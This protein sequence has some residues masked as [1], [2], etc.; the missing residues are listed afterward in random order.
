MAEPVASSQSSA[1]I[2]VVIPCYDLGR[3]IEEAVDSV[4]AQTYEAAEIVIVDDESAD[5]LTRQVLERL[6]R[7]RTSVVQV[8]HGGVARAR[9]HGVSLTRSDYIVLLDADDVLDERYLER[10]AAPL[11]HDP[12]LGFVSCPTQAF[13]GADYRWTPPSTD[14]VGTL[15]RGSVHVSSMFRRALW[16]AVGG[17]DVD[18]PAYEDLDFWLTAIERGFRGQIVD[19]TVLFYRVRADSRYRN[20]ISPAVYREAM[21]RIL[22]RHADLLRGRGF[23][24]LRE[25]EAFVADLAAHRDHLERERRRATADLEDLNRQIADARVGTSASP[26]GAPGS[27]AGEGIKHDLDRFLADRRWFV[28]GN[29]VVFSDVGWVAD[30]EALARWDVGGI[31]AVERHVAPG[32]VDPPA[33]SAD[34]VVLCAFEQAHSLEDQLQ[35]AARALKPN[36]TML[37]VTASPSTSEAFD[38]GLRVALGT[39]FPLA[40][41]DIETRSTVLTACVQAGTERRLPRL[42]W[43]PRS[44]PRSLP[45]EGVVLAYHRVAALDPDTHNLCITPER[46][47]AHLRYLREH[48]S[49]MSLT[50]LYLAS[51]AGCLPPRAVAIT[52]DDG[53]RDALT[54]AAP[55]LSAARLPGTFFV[56]TG[57]PGQEAWHDE[58]EYVLLGGHRLPAS[59]QLGTSGGMFTA[60]VAG[61]GDRLAALKAVHGLLFGASAED[62]SRLLSALFAWAGL[63]R[64]A[65]PERRVL[66]NDEIR[67]LAGVPGCEVGSHSVSHLALPMHAP[68]VQL[69]EL[70]ESKEALEALL[71]RPV[72]AFAYPFGEH[73]PALVEVVR[74]TP[75]LIA[76]TV[77]TGIV[78]ADADPM[79]LPRLEVPNA[80]AE[81]L[82]ALLDGLFA[83]PVQTRSLPADGADVWERNDRL[84]HAELAAGAVRLESL[85]QFVIIDPSSRCNARCVMCPVSFRAPG[86]TG[87]DLAAEIFEKLTPLLPSASQINLFS[88][89]EPTI[90]RG[91]VRM[92]SDVRRTSDARTQVC[93]STNGKRVPDAFVRE[94]IAPH[95]GLQFSVDGGTREVFEEVRRGIRFDDLLG[96]LSLAQRMKGSLPFP[97]L[98]FSS[99]MSKRNIHDLANI[100]EL[101][102][103]YGVEHVYFYDEDPEVSEEEPFLLDESD[104]AVFEA[105]LPRIE[106][107]GVA[108][109]NGLY[110]RG[111]DG[112]RAIEPPPPADPPALTCLAPWRVFHQKADGTVRTCCT[113]RKSMGDLRRQSFDEIWNGEEYRNSVRRSSIS[114]AFQARVT[115][116]PTRFARGA[117][118]SPGLAG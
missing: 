70:R 55:L 118:E 18:L 83:S 54:A 26:P 96:S 101:A 8:E 22:G 38:P 80:S 107:T 46:L 44:S 86:D 66:S 24:I 21:T 93:V 35:R 19:D 67:A 61:A 25:K 105:Q 63:E 104:R 40:S 97:T 13:E 39:T 106:A 58:V 27:P 11:D 99:T 94:L 23:D 12:S 76:V 52:F 82:A 87:T 16:T 3:T 89:G 77:R 29:V 78:S 50:D 84:A 33:S 60:S 79:R 108:Y 10:L 36:G 20:A 115:G 90:A 109:S 112:L 111:R 114:G 71:D 56:N 31:A 72:T 17:F 68:D 95:T 59:L 30:G 100:F 2:G 47:H 69:R 1:A 15:T 113:L 7:P 110:F 45:S 28:R 32:D 6:E 57:A 75:Y 85:P 91:I 53:Y 98:T 81:E 37:V 42:S 9:N 102:R 116:A 64:S 62:R 74:A 73:D 65:R 103:Q 41:F 48:C 117:G 51:R 49:V 34:T 5:L 88:S 43:R 92:V 14:A 4:L